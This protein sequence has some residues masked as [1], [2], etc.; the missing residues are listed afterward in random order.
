MFSP[1]FRN[2]AGGS[3]LTTGSGGSGQE[4]KGKEETASEGRG[5]RNSSQKKDAQRENSMQHH[6]Q[7]IPLLPRADSLFS[8]L[9]RADFRSSSESSSRSRALRLYRLPNSPHPSSCKRLSVSHTYTPRQHKKHDQSSTT[10]RDSSQNLPHSCSNE[11][12]IHVNN[13]VVL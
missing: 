10:D 7:L 8:A 13:L 2:P 12:P 1:Q 11:S 9:F 5:R 4:T 3:V 6:S